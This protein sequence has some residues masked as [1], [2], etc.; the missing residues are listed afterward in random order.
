MKRVLA[1]LN[2]R[3]EEF[4]QAPFFE[5]LRD[6]KL[7]ARERLSFAPCA[8]HFVMSFADLYAYVLKEEPPC[9]KFQE[10]VNA[11]TKEDENHWK[12]FLS[13]LEK[14]DL[15]PGYSFTDALRTVW[16]DATVNVRLLSYHMARL[17]YRADSI[18]K[19]VLIHCIEAAGKVTVD[20]VAD[21]GDEFVKETGARLVYLGRHH[22]DTEG[23][24]TIEQEG[25]HGMVEEIPLT[26]EK[27]TELA[28]LVDSTFRYFRAF[29]DD[30][31]A[32]VK[33]GGQRASN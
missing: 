20:H 29:T 8:A 11:H 18:Q 24:H 23:E 19:L 2:Q 10:L 22:S 5:Y 14:L 15:N 32:Y 31:L 6:D 21:V 12:W 16:S 4:A 26:E 30:M 1:H 9:D 27:A 33:S 13:D 28:V 3:T 25:V 7:P 17:G